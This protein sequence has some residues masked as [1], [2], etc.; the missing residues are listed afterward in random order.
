[1]IIGTIALL[2]LLIF[3]GGDPGVEVLLASNI[4]TRVEMYITD[5][6]TK[7]EIKNIIQTANE[8]AEEYN[9][10]L[11]KNIEELQESNLNQ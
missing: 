6:N 4:I 10:K 2:K 11:E 7:D 3:G 9:D 1:M 5:E 8:S